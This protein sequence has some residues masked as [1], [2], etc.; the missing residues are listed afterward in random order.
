MALSY[1]VALLTTAA[2]VANLVGRQSLSNLENAGFTLATFLLEAQRWVY[3]RLINAGK[4]PTTLTNQNYLRRPIA[5]Y[6][7]AQL[8]A[9]GHVE[10]TE[11]AGAE[12]YLQQAEK[13][14]DEFRPIYPTGAESRNAAEDLPGVA[15]FDEASAFPSI[16]GTTF[17]RTTWP[18]VL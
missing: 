18:R 2:E 1:D 17:P 11:G 5:L 8:V 16:D 10:I 4:D 9:A 6:V 3:E 13:L 12:F 7:V 14:V 15:N